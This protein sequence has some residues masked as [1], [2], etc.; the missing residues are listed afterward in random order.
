MRDKSILNKLKTIPE[1][2]GSVINRY[3]TRE[4]LLKFVTIGGLSIKWYSRGNIAIQIGDD[5]IICGIN[6]LVSVIQ[7]L[8][9]S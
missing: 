9:R 2:D 7:G 8:I 1:F 5:D 6:E 4:G 3:Q